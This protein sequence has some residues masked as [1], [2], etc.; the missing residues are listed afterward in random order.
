[1]NPWE[2]FLVECPWCGCTVD[3]V[4]YCT[5]GE[6]EYVEDCS[7]CCAPM[8]VRVSVVGERCEPLVR[9]LREGE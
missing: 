7:A 5:A 9:V 1:M 3:L 2:S 4:V 6:Q 8:L